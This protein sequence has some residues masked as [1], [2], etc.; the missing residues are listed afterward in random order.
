MSMHQQEQGRSHSGTNQIK[1]CQGPLREVFQ[2]RH[3]KNCHALA[4][5]SG[6]YSPVHYVN[7]WPLQNDMG[8]AQKTPARNSY[9]PNRLQ[10]KFSSF[11]IL[12]EVGL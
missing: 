6:P 8:R 10:G 7:V 11:L 9:W 2:H 12:L 5:A 1:P 4:R 3:C